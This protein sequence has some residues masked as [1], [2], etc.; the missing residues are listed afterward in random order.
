MATA[1]H[2]SWELIRLRHAVPSTD[3]QKCLLQPRRGRGWQGVAGGGGTLV[4]SARP[5][6]PTLTLPRLFAD[7]QS[8]D[9]D[10]AHLIR[11]VSLRRLAAAVSGSRLV[12]LTS[13]N[14][15]RLP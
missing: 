15:V 2:S 14:L 13:S 7:T 10:T 3:R 1:E 4:P 11:L 6:R 5:T 9:L 8:F 12:P